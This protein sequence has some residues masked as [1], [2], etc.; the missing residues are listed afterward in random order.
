MNPRPTIVFQLNL[1]RQSQELVGTKLNQQNVTV[2]HPDQ[3]DDYHNA[4]ERAANAAQHHVN[5]ACWIP[6]FLAGENIDEKNGY[7]F[8]AYGEKALYLKRTFAD[9][10][11]PLLTVISA[12]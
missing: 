6:G 3:H 1:N 8:T 5:K 12:E 4:T 11:N 9:V 2:L 10:D 7:T